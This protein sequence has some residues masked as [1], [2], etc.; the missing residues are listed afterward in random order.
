MA[1]HKTRCPHYPSTPLQQGRETEQ[2]M[3]EE[4]SPNPAA[5][6]KEASEFLKPTSQSPCPS[7]AGSGLRKAP[8]AFPSPRST[9]SPFM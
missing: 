1:P 5:N 2:K 8:Q 7:T 6:Q 9:D 4:Y 3:L